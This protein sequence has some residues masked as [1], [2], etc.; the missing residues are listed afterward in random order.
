MVRVDPPPRP[1]RP[2]RRSDCRGRHAEPA[3][4][5][6]TF[7]PAAKPA[8]NVPNVAVNAGAAG[9][10]A[11]TFDPKVFGESSYD[12]VTAMLMAVVIGAL[13]GVGRLA[14]SYQTYQ[15]V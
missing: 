10:G 9:G 3:M 13:L 8:E 11:A 14:L 12:Q 7:A 2:G 5:I 15:A 1:G 4:K 6:P